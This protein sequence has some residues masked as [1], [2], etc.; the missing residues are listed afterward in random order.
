MYSHHSS[1][2]VSSSPP[3][4]TIVAGTVAASSSLG[5]IAMMSSSWIGL[6]RLGPFGCTGTAW[7]ASIISRWN[8]GQPPLSP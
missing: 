1:M 8:A 2:L 4:L 5:S 7:P 3:Q 6:K